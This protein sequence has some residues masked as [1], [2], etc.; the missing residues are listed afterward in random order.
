MFLLSSKGEKIMTWNGLDSGGTEQLWQQDK[1]EGILQIFSKHQPVDRSD[2]S[3]PIYAELEAAF[4]EITWRNINVD[5]SFRP[6]FRKSHPTATLGL[7]EKT[8]TGERVTSRGF[9]LMNGLL[10]IDQVFSQAAREHMEKD[11]ES[12]FAIIAS[13]LIEA[14]NYHFSLEDIEHGICQHYNPDEPNIEDALSHVSGAPEL[15]TTRRRRLRHMMSVLQKAGAAKPV[16]KRWQLNDQSVALT[17]SDIVSSPKPIVITTNPVQ[18]PK[19][20]TAGKSIRQISSTE[21]RSKSFRHNPYS[22]QD[23]QKRSLL[24]EKANSIHEQLVLSVVKIIEDLGGTATEDP[25]SY[26][27]GV[28]DFGKVLFEMKSTTPKNAISQYRKAVSQLSEYR[29][30]NRDVFDQKTLLIIVTDQSPSSLVDE[31]YFDYLIKDREL[32]LAWESSGTLVCHTGQTLSE[33]LIQNS[34]I[35]VSDPIVQ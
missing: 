11:G 5:G 1:I 12:S 31:D 20:P 15:S 19:H 10:T 17:I 13:A 26:D 7:T 3:S 6:I 18:Q 2:Q 30:R 23:P 25:N 8:Q 16:K 27:V 9:D 21:D 34:K 14:P 35:D 4:P 32:T 22:V 33:V 28:S 29:W 24:L